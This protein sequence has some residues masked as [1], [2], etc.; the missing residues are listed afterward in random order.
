MDSTRT[1][2]SDST[3]I[4]YDSG[5]NFDRISISLQTP[6]KSRVAILPLKISCNAH[7]QHYRGSTAMI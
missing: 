7:D 6:K 4:L 3:R 5:L 2:V 1:L